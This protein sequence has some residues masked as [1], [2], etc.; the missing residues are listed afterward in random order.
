LIDGANKKK[1]LVVVDSGKKCLC[2]EGLE[3]VPAKSRLNLWAK[4]PAPPVEVKKIS[5]VVPH[6]TPIDDVPIPGS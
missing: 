2:S 6:F 4:F 5:V 3:P 1:Y